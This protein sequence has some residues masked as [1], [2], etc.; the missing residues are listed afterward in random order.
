MHTWS[1]LVLTAVWQKRCRI[2]T[3]STSGKASH[4]RSQLGGS[5]FRKLWWCSA[6]IRMLLL[7]QAVHINSGLTVWYLY[8][9]Q[10]LTCLIESGLIMWQVFLLCNRVHGWVHMECTPMYPAL[11]L[12]TLTPLRQS[13]S[14]NLKLGWHPGSPNDLP[15]PP[16]IPDSPSPTELE[17][18]AQTA[19]TSPA[20]CIGVCFSC[21]YALHSEHSNPLNVLQD[22]KVSYFESQSWA[23]D[24]A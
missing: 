17:L 18:K 20:L 19:L 23:R 24:M 10:S 7:T 9:V 22:L 3:H 1:P 5:W 8:Y 14:L 6:S 12:F 4:Q 2:Y 15:V 21:I 11:S 13:L 16:C